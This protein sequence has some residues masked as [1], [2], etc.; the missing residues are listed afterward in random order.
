MIQFWPLPLSNTPSSMLLPVA[1]IPWSKNELISALNTRT[2][3]ICYFELKEILNPDS[4]YCCKILNPTQNISVKY[5]IP[6]QNTAV[7]YWNWVQN[8]AVKFWIQIQNINVKYWIWF[9]ISLWSIEPQIQNITV[10][11][12]NNS[13]LLFCG[14]KILYDPINVKIGMVCTLNKSGSIFP[15]EIKSLELHLNIIFWT[16]VQYFPACVFKFYWHR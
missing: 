4:K 11:Y 16:F 6:V 2:R 10:Q 1:I 9:K 15:I 12:L 3:I 5:W 13:P 14:I 8:T 7:K